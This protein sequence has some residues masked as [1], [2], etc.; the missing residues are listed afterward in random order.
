MSELNELSNIEVDEYQ[1]N[2]IERAVS[3]INSINNRNIGD[4]RDLVDAAD[5]IQDSQIDAIE[6]LSDA[7]EGI[8]YSQVERI[9]RITNAS[10][11]V[12]QDQVDMIN[13]LGRIASE[14]DESTIEALERIAAAN[15][16]MENAKQDRIAEERAMVE[17]EEIV[18]ENQRRAEAEKIK[19]ED[20]ERRRE[21][22]KKH[23]VLIII[24][25]IILI[26]GIALLVNNYIFNHT[27]SIGISN[28]SVVGEDYMSVMESLETRGFSNVECE[29]RDDI[30]LKDKKLENTVVS[31]TVNGRTEY[32]EDSR[33]KSDIPIVIYYHVLKEIHP[34]ISSDE[35]KEYSYKE[36]EAL[37][38]QSGF[39]V[40]KTEEVK[41]KF[42][43]DMVK[44]KGAIK[45][46]TIDGEKEFSDISD[47]RPDVEV[48]IKYYGK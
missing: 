9:E 10:E 34:P 27:N 5:Y 26:V 40:V 19:R 46:I 17:T 32:T 31:V 35:L 8:D 12:S 6:R 45:S 13:D 18:R 25:S 22:L 16:T 47:F 37:F 1:I 44:K 23:S 30:R 39:G 14:I 43:V 33:Y 20:R 7:A 36:A 4:V 2:K 48:I 3:A 42:L 11:S 24:A 28:K 15:I 41:K 38:K 21:F 29:P